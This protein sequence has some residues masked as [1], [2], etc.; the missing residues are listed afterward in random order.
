MAKQKQYHHRKPYQIAHMSR[1]IQRDPPITPL[2]RQVQL[3]WHGC[4]FGI[5]QKQFSTNAR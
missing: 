3:R 5:V 2:R 4:T 1:D